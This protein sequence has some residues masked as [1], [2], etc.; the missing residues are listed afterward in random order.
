[1]LAQ[2]YLEA[3]AIQHNTL[4]VCVKCVTN[5][6]YFFCLIKK[7]RLMQRKQVA[8]RNPWFESGLTHRALYPVR[9]NAIRPYIWRF[10]G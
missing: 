1:M 10:Q 8:R 5:A 2:L 6:L 9:A 3:I 4:L 7:I